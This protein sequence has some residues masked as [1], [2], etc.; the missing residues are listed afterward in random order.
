MVTMVPL[1]LL[2][3]VVLGIYLILVVPDRGHLRMLAPP[4]DGDS[5]GAHPGR[6]AYEI[7]LGV[8]GLVVSGSLLLI[9]LWLLIAGVMGPGLFF[10]APSVSGPWP[11]LLT[12]VPALLVG[13]MGVLLGRAVRRRLLR[14]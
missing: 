5:P 12:I 14:L 13:F 9:S 1:L 4:G 6:V 2:L 3:V 7:T 10:Y 11:L 8:L